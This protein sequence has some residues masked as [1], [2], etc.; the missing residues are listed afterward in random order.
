MHFTKQGHRQSST[1]IPTASPPPPTPAFT[2]GPIIAITHT[3]HQ[4]TARLSPTTNSTCSHRLTSCSLLFSNS[5]ARTARTARQWP[6]HHPGQSLHTPQPDPSPR[7]NTC[8]KGV[9]GEWRRRRG[10][11][12]LPTQASDVYPTL[13]ARN[14][15]VSVMSVTLTLQTPHRRTAG[16]SGEMS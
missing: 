16:M 10:C 7:T 3:S 6:H 11:P 12:I 15:P 4:R 14:R 1:G 9:E 5:A 13:C 8:E 2:H